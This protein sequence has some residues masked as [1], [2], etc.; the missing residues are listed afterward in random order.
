MGVFCEFLRTQ[1]VEN[2]RHHVECGT[3]LADTSCRPDT[4]YWLREG[5]MVP[6]VRR[7]RQYS[8]KMLEFSGRWRDGADRYMLAALP[9]HHLPNTADL[10]GLASWYLSQWYHAMYAAKHS[11]MM[12][13]PNSVHG[14]LPSSW[15][16]IQGIDDML[17]VV[18]MS[19]LKRRL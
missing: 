9:Y 16:D 19:P 8:F 6:F 10:Y 11:E 3:V 12:R 7:F 5:A 17:V 15:G 2:I 13:L 4:W 18:W 1:T 14:P